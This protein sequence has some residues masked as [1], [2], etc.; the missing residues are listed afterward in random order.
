MNGAN[1]TKHGGGSSAQRA[2]C[3]RRKSWTGKDAGVVHRVRWGQLTTRH[4]VAQMPG[5]D[6]R[7]TAACARAT[8]PTLAQRAGSHTRAPTL[9]CNLCRGLFDQKNLHNFE[10]N[11]K[12][13]EHES[14]RPH[15]LL[16]LSQR[17]TNVFSQLFANKIVANFGFFMMQSGRHPGIDR[18]VRGFS[19]WNF[20]CHQLD[21]MCSR[22]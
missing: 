2:T 20:K 18:D 14:G 8:R 6:P 3:G 16:Q 1:A 19:T 9:F 4:G 22:G 10:P 7:R 11:F 21:E 12:I 17:V 5:W 15:T 13:S